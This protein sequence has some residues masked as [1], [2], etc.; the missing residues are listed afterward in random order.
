MSIKPYNQLTLTKPVAAEAE[1]PAEFAEH[2]LDVYHLGVAP[3]VPAASLVQRNL[4]WDLQ[5]VS[6]QEQ[7]A[8]DS[9]IQPGK[10]LKVK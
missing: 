10:R 4:A 1:Q 5:Q 6:F 2:L 9:Q 8:V 7:V 3:A